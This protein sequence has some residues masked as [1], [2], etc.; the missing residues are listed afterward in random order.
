[1]CDISYFFIDCTANCTHTNLHVVLLS[2]FEIDLSSSYLKSY[3]SA[4]LLITDFSGTA[5]TFAYSTLS[6]VIFFSKN[7]KKLLRNKNNDLYYFKD[8]KYVGE[9]CNNVSQLSSIINNMNKKK[10]FYSKRIQLIRKERIKYLNKSLNKTSKVI[11]DLKDKY[12]N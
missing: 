12:F 2:N 7:E 1:M 6:P 11:I 5:Y 10:F 8:R 4:K 3:A 9:I